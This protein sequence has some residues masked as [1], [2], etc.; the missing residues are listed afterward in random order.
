MEMENIIKKIKFNDKELVPII[1]QQY[2]TGEVLMMAWINDEAL[3]KTIETGFVHYYSRSRDKLWQ[4]GET[5]GQTQQV[6]D[7]FLDCDGDTILIKIDQKG[8]ACHTGNKTCFFTSITKDGLV[9]K[10]NPE[11]SPEELYG[12]KHD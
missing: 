6:K 1:A 9:D 7:I 11:I 12:T 5:S 10:S 2:D 3:Q 8:V 4:K